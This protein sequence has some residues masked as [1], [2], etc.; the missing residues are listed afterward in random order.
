MAMSKIV[1]NQE[2]QN[3][4]LVSDTSSSYLFVDPEFQSFYC[5]LW[6]KQIKENEAQGFCLDCRHNLCVSCIKKH[7]K[8]H[9]VLRK[10]QHIS[11]WGTLAQNKY[12]HCVELCSKHPFKV[13]IY[14][15]LLHDD[16][17]CE[18]CIILEH[19]DCDI[20][21]IPEKSAGK[22]FMRTLRDVSQAIN[23]LETLKQEGEYINRQNL[24]TV[25]RSNETIEQF[26]TS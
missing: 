12:E 26:V 3:A 24:L 10:P 11:V 22:H 17:G 14:H 21:L 18:E 13:I 25:K 2:S 1:S 19:K 9:R 16:F 15:C 8:H 20:E 4:T 23:D 6:W 5:R 7:Q